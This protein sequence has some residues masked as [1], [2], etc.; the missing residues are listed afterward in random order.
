MNGK[1]RKLTTSLILQVLWDDNA[2]VVK[3]VVFP[4]GYILSAQ[5]YSSLSAVQEFI[6]PKQ[7]IVSRHADNRWQYQKVFNNSCIWLQV[8]FPS[9]QSR[10]CIFW[11]LL[12]VKSD[13]TAVQR[14][15]HFDVLLTDLKIT[16]FHDILAAW[17]DVHHIPIVVSF[18]RGDQ[19]TYPKVWLLFLFNSHAFVYIWYF[20][21]LTLN[22]ST[23]L[24]HWPMS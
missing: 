19:S 17:C 11:L 9:E 18:M 1:L 22:L 5:T 15:F 8:R 14:G 12:T 6:T 2:S 10:L 20:W 16:M 3:N 24:S 7:F 13:L 23:R 4:G 21:Y